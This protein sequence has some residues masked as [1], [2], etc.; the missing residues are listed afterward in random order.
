MVG[1][2]GCCVG[3]GREYKSMHG[4]QEAPSQWESWGH[5]WLTCLQQHGNEYTP[6]VL[7]RKKKY[8]YFIFFEAYFKTL[9]W[10]SLCGVFHLFQYIFQRPCKCTQWPLGANQNP[11]KQINPNELSCFLITATTGTQHNRKLSPGERGDLH[12]NQTTEYTYWGPLQ[13]P[14]LKAIRRMSAWQDLSLWLKVT[15]PRPGWSQELGAPSWGSWT[16]ISGCIY[17]H[18]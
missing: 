18:G 10:T 14:F 3:V 17:I 12:P 1:N 4:I 6:T 5:L 15:T 8:P 7:K 2:R 16:L 9:G 13:L 11:L